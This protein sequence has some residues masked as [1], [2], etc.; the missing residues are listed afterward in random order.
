MLTEE[1]GSRLKIARLYWKPLRPDMV[2]SL[3][4]RMSHPDFLHWKGNRC[5]PV[6]PRKKE[7]A[8]EH[9]AVVLSLFG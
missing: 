4:W 3:G 9:C 7:K 8:N 6:M 5:R 2:L 1:F